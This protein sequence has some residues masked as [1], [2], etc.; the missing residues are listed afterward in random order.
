ML[1]ESR[2][3]V[4]PILQP[5]PLRAF[6]RA[7]TFSRLAI[8]PSRTVSRSTTWSGHLK[9]ESTSFAQSE[10]LTFHMPSTY[11]SP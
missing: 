11:R 2:L 7:G 10:G 6:Y 4:V 9:L 1:V 3:L 5:T 8:K